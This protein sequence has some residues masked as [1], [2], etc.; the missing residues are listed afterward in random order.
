M[1]RGGIGLDRSIFS[2]FHSFM[3][4]RGD[5][6]EDVAGKNG[7]LREG[8]TRLISFWDGIERDIINFKRM[9]RMPQLYLMP[10]SILRALAL[11]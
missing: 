4:E 6:S 9:G 2:R 7:V 5:F 11:I 3:T 8:A 1:R 10:A